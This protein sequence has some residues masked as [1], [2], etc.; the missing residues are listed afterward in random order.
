LHWDLSED[1]ETISFGTVSR[2]DVPPGER[3]ALK[4]W[5]ALPQIKP[6][7]E[8]F[9]DLDLV[10]PVSRGL[11]PAGHVYATAQFGLPNPAVAQAVPEPQTVEIKLIESADRLLLQGDGVSYAFDRSTG[12]LS[13]IRRY[14]EE[15]ML[16][17]L[18]PNFWRAPTDNDFGNYMQD[19]A[20]VWEQAG[21][22]R[23]LHHFEFV[24][25]DNGEV[26]VSA[27]YV[28][29]DEQG[30]E[31]GRWI[32]AYRMSE[33]GRLH[34]A[35]EFTRKEGLPVIPRVGMNMELIA[36]LDQVS[37]FGRGPHE[38]YWDRKRSARVG[39]YDSSVAELY[40]PYLRPQENGYRT[41][42]RH[43]AFSDG[44]S[45]LK[46]EADDVIGFSALHN[47]MEDFIPPVKIAITSE[48]GPGARDN[49]Q[50]VNIHVNDIKPRDLVSINIDYGQ[51]GVG[52]D[53]SWGKRT[54]PQYTLSELSYRYGFVIRPWVN[55][56]R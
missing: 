36:K 52:G 29:S 16:R 3:R 54:L 17:P 13:S 5:N 47:R 44:Y 38:N 43:V 45:G 20:A 46:V 18:A 31:L 30:N 1:G 10:S 50:R 49:E 26:K 23:D 4:L 24:Q 53:D 14:S 6:G 33:G 28:F 22:N 7:S 8:Y 56:K 27:E 40:V 42:T 2:L 25:L 41:D 48:D 21:R 37:W 51:M 15:W 34:V 12:L 9:L 32:A 35:N 11:L 55:N 19:W 39:L